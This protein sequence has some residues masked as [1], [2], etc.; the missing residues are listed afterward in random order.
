MPLTN[1][2]IYGSKVYSY[3]PYLCII[4]KLQIIYLLLTIDNYILIVKWY[5]ML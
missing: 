4:Y 1:F 5:I 2:L 3:F